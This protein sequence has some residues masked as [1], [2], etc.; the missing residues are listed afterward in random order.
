MENPLT[1]QLLVNIDHQLKWHLY[2]YLRVSLWDSNHNHFIHI[3]ALIVKP[4]LPYFSGQ[5]FWP[6]SPQW[7]GVRLHRGGGR[8]LWVSGGWAAGGGRPPH[9]LNRG[10]WAISFPSGILCK[11]IYLV[12]QE[13]LL[14]GL[15]LVLL[16]NCNCSA[17]KSSLVNSQKF[18]TSLLL[19]S[20]ITYP[21]I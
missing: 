15:K 12:V 5:T 6:T 4:N 9:S 20:Q 2:Q 19:F 1:L 13:V 11:V 18:I 16:G 8:L 14:K 21:E 7:V 10:W 17:T 3:E